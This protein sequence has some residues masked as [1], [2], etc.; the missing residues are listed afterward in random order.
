MDSFNNS[1]SSSR[2]NPR[3]KNNKASGPVVV[4]LTICLPFVGLPQNPQIGGGNGGG[5]SNGGGIP[6]LNPTRGAERNTFITGEVFLADGAG[7]S[8]PIA[9]V[10]GCRGSMQKLGYTDLK[11]HFNIDLKSGSGVEDATS[12]SSRGSSVCEVAA[13]LDGYRSDTVDLTQRSSPDRADIGTILMHRIGE[14][15][16]RTVSLTSL[17]APKN[18]RSA[19]DKGMAL[20]RKGRFDE[21]ARQFEK[22]VELYPTYADAWYRLG[23]VQVQKNQGEAA[24]ASFGKA[25]QADPKLVPPYVELAALNVSEGKWQEAVESSQRAIRLDPSGVPAVYFFHA[26]GNYNLKNWEE[27]EK[28]ARQ[29]QRLDTQ[30][31]FV[32]IHRMLGALL[33][34]KRDYAG[35]AEQMRAY[36]KYAG[37]AKDAGEVRTQL[38]ELEKRM[39]L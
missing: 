20:F 16:G 14:Q 39:A 29:V 36:L 34:A 27:S 32:Q 28:S 38:A 31:R 9:I 37:D 22:A 10:G 21:A 35:A 17:Q 13:Q 26:L 7:I 18:A 23:H 6:R 11:G 30:H 5:G 15:E 3:R 1:K 2:S 8:A 4:L 33:T 25:I 19:F 12:P 24:R